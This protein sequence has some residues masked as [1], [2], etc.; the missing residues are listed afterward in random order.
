MLRNN[1]S[2]TRIILIVVGFPPISGK[3]DLK[4]ILILVDC[5]D[6]DVKL[7]V[8]LVTAFIIN[9]CNGMKSD[10]TEFTVALTISIEDLFRNKV[11]LIRAFIQIFVLYEKNQVFDI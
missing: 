5:D 2:K 10:W 3:V 6:L 8:I 11:A 7:G 4:F 9:R 1:P